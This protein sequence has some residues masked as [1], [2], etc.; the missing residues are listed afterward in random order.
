MDLCRAIHTAQSLTS[1]GDAM[2]SCT[3]T[4]SLIHAGDTSTTTNVSSFRPDILAARRLGRSF[5]ELLLGY[6][7][8]LI[9]ASN[10]ERRSVLPCVVVFSADDRV[11]LVCEG[12]GGARNI[13]SRSKRTGRIVVMLLHVLCCQI[14]PT[15]IAISNYLSLSHFTHFNFPPVG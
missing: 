3:P 9:R 1:R 2:T 12:C 7:R 5:A 13:R 10:F 15:R 11:L 8:I 14:M 4:P 6:C